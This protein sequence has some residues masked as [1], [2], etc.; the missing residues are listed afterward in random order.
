MKSCCRSLDCQFDRRVAEREAR[1]L[2]RK[3][4]L[5]ST[6]ML[7]ED[8]VARGVRGDV[9]LDVGGGLGVIREKL[10]EAGASRALSVDA[11][12]AFTSAAR[13]R[14]EAQGYAD[15]V[16]HRVA[17]FVAVA[18]ELPDA[19]VVAL[20][21]VICCYPDLDGML[22]ASTRRARRLVGAVYPRSRWGVRAVVALQNLFRRLR[23]RDFR[24]YVFPVERIVGG[25][26]ARGFELL[27]R[28]RTFV[29]EVTVFE[30]NRTE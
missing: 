24:A 10:L 11:S 18:D 12:E 26:E 20:D 8:L 4:P 1:R 25:M 27:S 30:R 5:R 21:R 17:D 6:S 7:A 13:K 15:R 2:D 28:R 29:W 16:E 19:D 14:A 23:R 22:D 3:G 9:V